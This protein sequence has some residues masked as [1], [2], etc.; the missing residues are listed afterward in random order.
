MRALG[1]AL[2]LI[3]PLAVG[4]NAGGKDGNA[5][6]EAAPA[7]EPTESR[8]QVEN[9]QYA[10]WAKSPAGTVAVH[11]TVVR[12]EGSDAATVMTTTY[13]LLD[14][15]PDQAVVQMQVSTK[16]YD[17]FEANDRPEKFTHPKSLLLPPGVKK[18]RA[19]KPAGVTE[20]GEESISVAGKEYKAKWYKGKDR[21]EGGEMFTQ[22]WSSAEVPGE[23][24]KS[25][26]RT[27]A[28]GKTTTIELV[29]IRMP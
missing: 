24:L 26:T 29:E 23:L 17:G 20:E 21:N 3:A 18:D 28:I 4:C 1:I 19:G 25:V 13:T 16:R 22:M 7:A 6:A 14:V 2:A 8:E 9:P 12:G 15:T 27:P 11:K 10:S 5:I